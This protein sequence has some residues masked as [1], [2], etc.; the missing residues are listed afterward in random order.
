MGVKLGLRR[1]WF[2]QM[3]ALEDEALGSGILAG[4]GVG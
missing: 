1:W 4:G 3:S 2:F